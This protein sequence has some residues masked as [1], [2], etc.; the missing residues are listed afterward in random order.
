MDAQQRAAWASALNG[1]RF[2]KY[3]TVSYLGGGGFSFVYLAKDSSSG[4][5]VALKILIPTSS[6]AAVQE[7]RTEGDLLGRLKQSSGVVTILET[8]Q[9]VAQISFNS[10][11]L[12]LPIHFH[13]LELASG[14]LE[15]LLADRDKLAWDERLRLW[16]GVIMGVHQMHLQ[17]M[18]HRDLK[19]SNCLLMVRRRNETVCKVSDLG[20][21]R[22]LAQAARFDPVDY[23][24]GRGDLRFAPPEF[25]WLQGS[26][27]P[28][29]HLASDL[30][31]L[32]SILFELATGVGLTQ[33]ALGFGPNLVRTNIASARAGQSIDL[34]ILE[35][36]YESALDV[37]A[38]ELPRSIRN[39]ARTLIKQL[40]SPDPSARWPRARG[41]RI[42]RGD[43]LEWLLRQ[44]DIL[45]KRL[46]VAPQ[47]SPTR[48]RRQ[49]A[50]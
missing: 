15:E 5:D 1:Q 2:G 50:S 7:F 12:D 45:L 3:E 34:K 24:V 37:F 27:T 4:A 44:V 33:M 26:E 43:G 42:Q 49:A 47:N 28:D 39:E 20:R 17:R 32:G 25:L 29:G 22:D 13:S 10:I 30:Y 31:G 11:P 35:P 36:K 8:G 14:C 6:A 40:T 18:A 41:R 46:K 21:S 48:S 19:S 38:N 9:D 16:R 23:L